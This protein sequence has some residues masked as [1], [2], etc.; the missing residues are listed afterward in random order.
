MAVC[1]IEKTKNYT[2]MSNCHLRD[3]RLSLKAVGLLSV[4]LSL[5]EDWDYTTRGLA[6]I[7]KDGVEAI[8]AALRELEHC[9]YLQQRS[10][11]LTL[12]NGIPAGTAETRDW[13]RGAAHQSKRP[14]ACFE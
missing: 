3:K 6:I 14:K 8:G 12:D 7:C 5:P 1:R 9:G 11:K 2:V 4:M 10:K 13:E